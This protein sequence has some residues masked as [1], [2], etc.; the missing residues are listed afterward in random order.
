V[1]GIAKAVAKECAG[2]PLGIITVARSLR[3]VDDLHEWRNTLKKLKESEFRDNEVFKLL[4]F[5]YDRLGHLALQQCLLY[6]ALFPED[7]EIGREDLIGYLID[8]GI[9]KV[10]RTRGDAFDEGHTML[11]RLE[12]VCL[13]ESSF[14][15][16]HVK[17]HDLI[18]DM[19]IHILLEN[20]QAMVKAGAQLKELPDIEEWTENLTIVSL[21]KN[22]I[23]EI[24]S[25][26]S[27][28][29]P[30]L[31]SLFL[32]ENEELRLIADSFFKQLHGL[33]VLDLSWT[34]I[35]NLPDSVSDLVSLTA[36]LLN[37]CENLRH[38]PS[39]KKLTAL[40]RLDL[41]WT[42][43]EKMPQGMECLT[44]LRYLRMN[45]CGEEEFPSGILPKLSHL[46]V[47]V[48]EQFAARGDGPITVKGKEV[49]SLRNLESLECHFEGFSD[50]VEYLRS[51]DGIL[52]LSTYKILVGMVDEDYPTYIDDCLTCIVDYPSKTVALSNLS[53]NGDRDFQVKFLNGIQGLHC[54]CIDATSLCDV[55][56]L[57]NATEVERIGIRDCNNMESLVSSSWFCSAPPPLP[58]Y[59]GMFSG[60]KKLYCGGC[61]SMKKLFPLVLLPNLV[62]LERI[63]V[64][65]CKKMEEI[66]GTTDEESSTSNSIT[67][68]ILPKLRTL[69]LLDLP[70]L[71]SI[72]SAKLI[73]NSLED[74]TVIDCEKLKRMPIC[75]PLLENGQPSPPPSLKKIRALPEEWWESVV[76]WEH[77]NAKDVL[78][79]FVK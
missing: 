41:S 59:S 35:E 55:L 14:N 38:V 66:I 60:L 36:L 16:I 20:S 64:N 48:L 25:S 8:E 23:E 26:H 52:S 77:P 74:I 71:K 4:R 72:C 42:T 21:M 70:E 50:F 49:G 45:G 37:F 56:S 19:A 63:E 69:E 44:N 58:S 33:K 68:V 24:P 78:R 65:D 22:E 43:L 31:S 54:E 46:Q 27:P 13:L 32:R 75:L 9:I 73:C 76:E 67:E 39:L 1:E 18:R 57:E 30:N 10:K 62:N 28:M 29:C 47:F 5:S 51:W 79:S 7:S 6:C 11:N 3:G 40:K 2:L 15:H 53:F 61:K 34:G 12:Y 17:M